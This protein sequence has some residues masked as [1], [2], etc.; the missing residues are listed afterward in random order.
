[1]NKENIIWIVL[2]ILLV[3]FAGYLFKWRYGSPSVVE[4]YKD[5]A[6]QCEQRIDKICCLSSVK[7]MAEQQYRLEP[8][9]GCDEGFAKTSLGCGDSFVWCEPSR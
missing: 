7:I 9:K 3:G 1:M 2:L 5:M 8:K 4:Y 6:A